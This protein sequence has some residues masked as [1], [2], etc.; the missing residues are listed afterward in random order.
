MF[1]QSV[2]VRMP[3]IIVAGVRLQSTFNLNIE[4][5]VDQLGMLLLHG[6]DQTIVLL[7]LIQEGRVLI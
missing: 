1:I 5:W 4:T 2:A 3:D 6:L 7:V